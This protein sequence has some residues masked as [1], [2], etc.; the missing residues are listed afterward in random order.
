MHT[1]KVVVFLQEIMDIIFKVLVAGQSSIDFF[2]EQ[3]PKG[4]MTK[5]CTKA[6]NL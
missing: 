2:K 1:N 5:T 3:S 6:F 4:L